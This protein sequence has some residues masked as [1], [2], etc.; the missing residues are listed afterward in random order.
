VLPETARLTALVLVAALLA[1]LATLAPTAGASEAPAFVV[2]AV[3]DTGINPYHADFS[4][5]T[6]PDLA[7]LE[8]SGGFTKDPA[9]WLPGYPGGVARLDLSLGAPSYAAAKAADKA[10]FDAIPM[11][12]LRWI[13]GTK[14]IGVYDADN[15]APLNAEADATHVLDDDGHGTLSASVGVGNQ[16]GSCPRCLL[17]V[18]EGFSG[19]AWAA[20]QPWIDVISNSWGS[21]GNLPTEIGEGTPE[22]TR[23][24]AERGG[25]VL[26]AAGNG[27]ENGYVVPEST[28][29]SE[30]TGPG[31]VV[32]VGAF[33]RPAENV[34]VPVLGTGRPVHL[35]AQG[36]GVP[37]ADPFHKT[38]AATHSGTS[39]ATPIAAGVFGATLG[40]A[41]DA[42]DDA[43]PGPR[44]V[45]PLRVAA[46]G[47][48]VPG[49]PAL[50]DG[51]LSRAELAETVFLAARATNHGSLTFSPLSFPMMAAAA[52]PLGE[53]WGWVGRET[54]ADAV[55]I[56]LGHAPHPAK[57]EARSF[58]MDDAFIRDA[59]WGAWDKDGNGSR[60]RALP[61]GLP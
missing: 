31:W 54:V 47:A 59:R 50:E 58:F 52:R 30:K 40:A 29:F 28:W 49:S 36:V 53:G 23:A 44:K 34:R 55:A 2:V 16:F 45:G 38:N 32:T 43:R 14:I 17:V 13:P 61:S 15:A 11:K 37:G 20:S 10:V 8:A 60:E 25:T 9:T 3:V 6:Y 5:A 27:V 46:S 22:V 18:V 56:L 4:A 26:F 7:V 21:V 19:L 35:L 24:F 41:R 33:N 57:P 42:L 51:L 1:P 48:P 12:S 39:A